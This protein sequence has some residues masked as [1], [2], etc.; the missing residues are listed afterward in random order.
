MGVAAFVL[1]LLSLFFV[2]FSGLSWLL[3]ILAVVFSLVAFGQVRKGE[4]V[5]GGSVLAVAGLLVGLICMYV[6]YQKPNNTN[7]QTVTS[8]SELQSSKEKDD[9]QIIENPQL[10]YNE[11]GGR[12]LNGVVYNNTHNNYSLVTIEFTLYNKKGNQ[13]GTAYD[14]ISS[15]KPFV[16]WE[17][18]APIYEYEGKIYEW[19]YPVIKGW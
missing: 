9:F 14:S 2:Q 8:K 12:Y 3:C 5:T 18:S 16:K 1:A 7:E 11:Y 13:V 17:F 10:K 15:L 4:N 6:L 19:S